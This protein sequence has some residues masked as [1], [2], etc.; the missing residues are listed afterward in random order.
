MRMLS[1]AGPGAGKRT[2]FAVAPT[3][4]FGDVVIDVLVLDRGYDRAD[5][6]ALS[7]ATAYLADCALRNEE[8]NLTKMICAM[9]L[10]EGSTGKRK[11]STTRSN[12]RSGDIMLARAGFFDGSGV[13][14]NFALSF[15]IILGDH[16]RENPASE[17]KVLHSL[18]QVL[19]S[20]ANVTLPEL[21][22]MEQL[23]GLDADVEYPFA[24]DDV[25]QTLSKL[26]DHANNGYVRIHGD[27]EVIAAYV[28]YYKGTAGIGA[29]VSI[30]PFAND[31]RLALFVSQYHVT[32]GLTLNG[33]ESAEPAGTGPRLPS[34]TFSNNRWSWFFRQHQNA[35]DDAT[36]PAGSGRPAPATAQQYIR[37]CV[38]AI[39]NSV[40]DNEVIDLSPI[41]GAG[42][43]RFEKLRRLVERSYYLKRTGNA[44]RVSAWT[45]SMA[46]QITYIQA[47]EG[48]HAQVRKDARAKGPF[49]AIVLSAVRIV[50][51]THRLVTNQEATAIQA[52]TSLA[53]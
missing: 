23:L 9:N 35:A 7:G 6:G 34:L 2:S 22:T 19:R 4:E 8:F 15:D 30:S 36:L 18:Y 44:T 38:A 21:L 48:S 53:R 32:R 45:L 10:S 40:R 46:H 20:G 42:G 41:L 52:L 50:K 51:S 17:T 49:P 43:T 27:G 31:R 13:F 5:E 39:S 33:S 3:V 28:E 37:D 1:N 11:E 29:A 16:G 25:S 12:C 47:L 24:V 14:H 26:A